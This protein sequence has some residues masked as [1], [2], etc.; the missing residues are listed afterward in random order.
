MEIVQDGEE[1]RLVHEAVRD[2]ADDAIVRRCGFFILTSQHQSV[3]RVVFF[4]GG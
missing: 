3:L 2:A 1:A 4:A